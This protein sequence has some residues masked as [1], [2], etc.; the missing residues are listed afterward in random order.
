MPARFPSISV[1]KAADEARRSPLTEASARRRG[2]TDLSSGHDGQEAGH[3]GHQHGAQAEDEVH[4]DVSDESYVRA[5][6]DPG[7]QVHPRES[8][9]SASRVKTRSFPG[10]VIRMTPESQKRF[11]PNHVSSLSQQFSGD[12]AALRGVK[13]WVTAPVGLELAAALPPASPLRAGR[14]WAVPWR[15]PPAVKQ[16]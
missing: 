14:A 15:Q 11:R 8:G 13:T 16:E 7:H 6:E 3:G 4:R 5:G 12:R 2:V 1:Q 10:A 9:V